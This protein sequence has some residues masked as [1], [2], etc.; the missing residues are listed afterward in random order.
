MLKKA[1]ETIATVRK[2]LV[3]KENARKQ[4]TDAKEKAEKAVAAVAEQIA[5]L[6]DGKPDAPLE[7]SQKDAQDQLKTATEAE[8]TAQAAFKGREIHLKDAE[9]EAQNYSAAQARNKSAVAA[10]NAAAVKAKE[11]RKTRRRRM[12]PQPRNP[13]R[14]AS[15]GRWPCVSRRI[16][17]P[18][19]PR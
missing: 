16:P 19:P 18:S 7:K 2:D 14:P 3:D 13:R 4:A 17:R 8:S 11:A 12:R 6:P 1:N 9:V 5:K 10:A 15:S